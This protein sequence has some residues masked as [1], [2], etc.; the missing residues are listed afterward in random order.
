MVFC[1][2]ALFTVSW[3]V[4][5]ELVGVLVQ[6]IKDKGKRKKEKVPTTIPIV[7]KSDFVLVPWFC[8][9]YLSLYKDKE[10]G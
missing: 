8:F 10:K 1:V 3:L 9:N 4:L 2:M 5:S 6:F 7:T